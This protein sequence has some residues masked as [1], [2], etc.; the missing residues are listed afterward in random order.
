MS[1]S[2]LAVHCSRLRGPVSGRNC[3]GSDSRESGH[4]LIPL[5]P[6]RMTGTTG[7]SDTA[8]PV[9]EST[10]ACVANGSVPGQ[11]AA[12][13]KNSIGRSL[14]APQQKR[15]RRQANLPGR[16]QCLRRSCVPRARY[17]RDHPRWH[18]ARG[19]YG[20]DA[21]K[22]HRHPPSVG[23]IRQPSW[24]CAEGRAPLR[25][26][27]ACNPSGENRPVGTLDP[28]GQALSGCARS[29]PARKGPGNA[30]N[31]TEGSNPDRKF[32]GIKDLVAEGVGFEPTVPKGYN[33][34]RDRPVRPLRHPSAGDRLR[35]SG[36]G[37]FTAWAERA[38][39]LAGNPR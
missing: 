5:P 14:R 7:L 28:H 8:M 38:A 32:S 24:H 10:P 15:H 30:G 22:A 16:Y 19:P 17:R 34:F 23:A 11:T 4:S 2:R 36:D 33:G 1:P 21:H 29:R 18:E 6:D 26:G 35:G 25:N 9:M 20:R 13:T 12:E 39:S 3:F 31:R 37:L 27:T